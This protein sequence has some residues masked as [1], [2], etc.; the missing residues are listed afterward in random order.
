MTPF[1]SDQWAMLALVFV[2][3][4]VVG[5]FLMAGSRWKRRYREEAERTRELEAENARLRDEARELESL[6]QAATKSP[7]RTPGDPEPA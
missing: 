3:G 1:T 2:L 5:M 4:V 6:R 7:G